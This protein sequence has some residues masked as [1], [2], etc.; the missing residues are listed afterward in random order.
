MSVC[1]QFSN[2]DLKKYCIKEG[3]SVCRYVIFML[4]EQTII[5]LGFVAIFA[6]QRA[7]RRGVRVSMVRAIRQNS[8][9]PLT[10]SPSCTAI[11][12]ED[13][14]GPAP[15]ATPLQVTNIA[16]CK[17]NCR[18]VCTVQSKAGFRCTVW[19][20]VDTLPYQTATP[21]TR[22]KFYFHPNQR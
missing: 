21:R 8:E 13:I 9:E 10:L 6:V 3:I 12:G 15:Q 16:R 11:P 7:G 1:N 5:R 20:L 14:A 22:L 17:P 4:S 18:R 2:L 19:C